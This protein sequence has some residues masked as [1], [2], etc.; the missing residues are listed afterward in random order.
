MSEFLSCVNCGRRVNWLSDDEC[1]IRCTKWVI[2]DTTALPPRSL[3]SSERGINEVARQC[4]IPRLCR[5]S[6]FTTRPINTLLVGV[7]K[8]KRLH[9]CHVANAGLGSAQGF[10]KRCLGCGRA[11]EGLAP[12]C[13]C[14][15][16]TRFKSDGTGFI[17][18]AF[19]SS[20]YGFESSP[21]TP[22]P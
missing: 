22:C 2:V 14:G 10:K 21:S 8:A 4:R 11:V 17:R 7:Q 1:C 15:L 20:F 18:H 16:C 9:S 3:L 19:N 12:D 6:R 5:E 13:R